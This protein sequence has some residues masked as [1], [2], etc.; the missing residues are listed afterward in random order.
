M[1]ILGLILL[2]VGWLAGISLLTWIGLV[3]IIIGVV[4]FVVGRAHPIGGR[5]HWY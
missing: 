4:F 1:I 2:L 3:L 5:S